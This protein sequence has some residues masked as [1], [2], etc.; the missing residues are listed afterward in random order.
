MKIYLVSTRTAHTQTE[1]TELHICIR[2]CVFKTKTKMSSVTLRGVIFFGSAKDIAPAWGGPKRLGDRVLKHVV[3]TFEGHKGKVG[4]QEVSYSLKIFDPLEVFDPEKNGALAQ[5]R[6][7]LRHPH[8]FHKPGQAPD[9]MNQMQ[10]EI[11]TADCIII[12]SPEYNHSI[13]PAL[14]SMMDHFGGSNYGYKPSAIVTY[15]AGPFCGMR[16]AMALRPFL[17]ELGCNPISRLSGF[18]DAGNLF[19]EEGE[20][21]SEHPSA[22]MISQLPKQ[23]DQLSWYALALKNMREQVPGP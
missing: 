11:K 20:P 4:D 8:F 1:N 23:I 19:T 16:C 3:N 2:H 10:Q 5:S 15:S 12:V 21:N 6:G 17:S 18:P 14:S 7:E 22:R 13:P 9:P